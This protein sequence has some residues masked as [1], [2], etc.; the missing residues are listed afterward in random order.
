MT[1]KEV[2]EIKG[3]TNAQKERAS[4]YFL[5]QRNLHRKEEMDGTESEIKEYLR[6]KEKEYEKR[7]ENEKKRKEKK[8]RQKEEEKKIIELFRAA[9]GVGLSFESIVKEIEKKIKE[10]KNE[11]V[12][13]QIEEYKK[14]LAELEKKIV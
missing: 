2:L 1:E 10:K 12:L 13:Q 8:A 11:K 9:K 7:K 6:Q 14:K 4:A 3:L 5:M